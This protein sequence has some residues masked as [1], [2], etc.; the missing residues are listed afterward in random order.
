MARRNGGG[1][2]GEGVPQGQTPPAPEQQTQGQG[3]ERKPPAAEFRLG[4]IRATVWANH[5]EGHGTWYSVVVTR[6]YKD[7]KD[8]WKTAQSFGR[9]D[10]LVISEVV[11]MAYHWIN[12]Q[13]GGGQRSGLE[14]GQTD[15]GQDQ[16]NTGD[17]PIPF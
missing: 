13:L 17:D 16:G 5:S 1:K 6:S 14:N 7:G 8:Q 12:K 2:N 3:G 15:S 11:R 10:L 4:R 9:D